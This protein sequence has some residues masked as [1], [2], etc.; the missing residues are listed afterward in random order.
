MTTKEPKE[1]FLQEGETEPAIAT[2][3]DALERVS[4]PDE[5]VQVDLVRVAD[6]IDAVADEEGVLTED[7]VKK[8]ETF[9]DKLADAGRNAW[10]RLKGMPKDELRYLLEAD[11]GSTSL[12]EARFLED[13]KSLHPEFSLDLPTDKEHHH[14]QIARLLL[15]LHRNE[16]YYRR[17]LRTAW[18]VRSTITREDIVSN[19]G[20]LYT[21]KKVGEGFKVF[22]RI[23]ARPMSKEDPVEEVPLDEYQ[24]KAGM[25][26]PLRTIATLG[27]EFEGDTLE[28]VRGLPLPVSPRFETRAEAERFLKEQEALIEG[29]SQIMY[30]GRI[31][32]LKK[33]KKMLKK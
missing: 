14:A 33:D 16:D 9:R 5:E 10:T 12:A 13:F 7:E 3:D 22:T 24:R 23:K 18:E 28:P 15:E 19:S 20:G 30:P 25:A 26:G 29:V 21:L 4:T 6:I 32:V 1:N 2:P 8:L 17:H 11:H 27:T 31:E